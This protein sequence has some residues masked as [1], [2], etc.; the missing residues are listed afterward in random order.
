VYSLDARTGCIEWTFRASS[1]IR[2]SISVSADGREAYFGDNQ[3]NIYAIS[4]ASGNLIW[5]RHVDADPNAAITGTPL[6]VK[7][8]LYVPVSSLEETAAI[9]PHYP[10]CKFRGS[11]VALDART[12]RQIWKSYTISD[13]AK[14]TGKNPIGATTQ[15]PSGAPVWSASTAD[16]RRKTIYVA[17]GNNYSAPAGNHSDA[18]LALDMK[19]GQLLWSRQ[20]TPDDMWN[21]SCHKHRNPA[22][23]PPNSGH[24]S[25]FGASPILASLTDGRSLIVAAQK[26]GIVYALNPD[27]KGKI[28]WKARLGNGGN[29]GGIE[30][31]GALGGGQVYFPISDWKQSDPRAGGGLFA[32]RVATG[33]KV[34]H[35]SPPTPDCKGIRG[36]GVAQIAPATLIPGVVFSGAMDGHLRAYDVRNGRVIWDFDAARSFKTVDAV[37]AHGGSFNKNGSVIAGGMLFVQSGNSMGIPGNVLLAFSVDGK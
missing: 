21:Q 7:G 16:L 27:H 1:A 22:N 3:A 13:P 6:L 20:V 28:V 36:C 8:R 35:V 11:V 32:L 29:M 37:A 24:D 34:W 18:V 2:S 23:C 26:S 19:T 5:K 15:G 25:D 33:K 9:D 4:A 17:T 14:P 30:W 10:C 12:G 31:G